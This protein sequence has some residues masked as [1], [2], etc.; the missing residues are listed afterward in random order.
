[1]RSAFTQ[2]IK[3]LGKSFYAKDKNIGK[4]IGKQWRWRETKEQWEKEENGW[5]ERTA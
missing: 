5:D 1:M 4:D 3:I 2:K